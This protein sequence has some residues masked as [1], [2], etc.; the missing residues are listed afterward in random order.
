MDGITVVKAIKNRFRETGSPANIP[1]QKG[2]GTF[3]AELRSDGV[4]VNNLGNQ[5][6]LPWLVFQEAICVLIRN[7]GRAARGNAMNAKLGDEALPLDSI[8][9]HIAQVV[10]GKNI[11]ESVFRRITPIAGI[12]IW[13]GVCR[14]APG[15][16][17][18]Y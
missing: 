18:L 13:A 3:L 15:E 12:L 8:E 5:S 10:Y 7:G 11:G 16:L 14:T 9:G 17:V 4:L 1:L 6:F 2:G